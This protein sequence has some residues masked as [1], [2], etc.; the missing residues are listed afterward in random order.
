MKKCLL[1]AAT[2]SLPLLMATQTSF[3]AAP[4]TI[5]NQAKIL[6]NAPTLNPYALK[7]AVKGYNW[8]RK[9]TRISKPNILTIIDFS[10]PSNKKRVWVIDTNTSKTLMNVYTTQ[11]KGS[12]ALYARSFSNQF[13]TNKTSLG[14]YK[15]T[16]SYHGK[17]GLSE[18]LQG[19]ENGI[20]DN[21][22]RRTIVVHPAW[23][24]SPSFVKQNNR[25]GRSW[26]CFAIDP[27][28]S[29][30][31]VKITR[32]GSIL[33]AYAAQEKNDKNLK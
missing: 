1:I 14:V 29:S 27:A 32:G 17:H 8:A 23:Y 3:A 30:K 9:K 19:L 2:L 26:G 22:F 28:V 6:S 24:A 20:N 25:A 15:V 13:N 5:I 31:F 18:R 33:F 21:A 4:S 12:G 11:G 7:Y 10:L 16:N